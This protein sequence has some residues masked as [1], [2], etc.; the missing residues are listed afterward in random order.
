MALFTITLKPVEA[1][2]GLALFT[3]AV[4]T[5]HHHG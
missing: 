2:L 3:I 5:F 4:D 1:L